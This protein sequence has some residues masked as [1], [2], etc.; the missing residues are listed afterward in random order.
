[1]LMPDQAS[2]SESEGKGKASYQARLR[3]KTRESA[4]LVKEAVK[5][6]GVDIGPEAKAALDWLCREPGTRAT[7]SSSG[8]FGK[9]VFYRLFGDKPVVGTTITALKVF[10]TTGKGFADM[11]SLMKKWEKKQ[12]LIVKY[13]EAAKA[14]KFVSGNAIPYAAQ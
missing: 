12:G 10:E 2:E 14:Y 13:D 4:K 5:K 1:M 8:V 9:P 7:G 6:A 11:K 3:D